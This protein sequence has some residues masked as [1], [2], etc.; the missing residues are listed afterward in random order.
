M[1]LTTAQST[2]LTRLRSIGTS[3]QAVPLSDSAIRTL[4]LIAL[5]DLDLPVAAAGV[6]D[7][8]IPDLFSSS[9][10]SDFVLDGEAI[11]PL[12]ERAL[13]LN[14]EVETY[15]SCLASIHK[16]RLK[17]RQVLASQQFSSM[18]QVA[19]R[20]LLQYGQ[21]T[22]TALA[23]LLVWRKWLYD[24]DNRAAQDTGYLFEPVIAGA[25]GG[26]PVSASRSP[27]RRLGRGG[28]RQVDCIKGFI[29]YE[30]KI[31][32]TIAASGQ[33][34]WAEELSFPEEAR[35][36]GFEPVL[37]V[38]DPTANPKL[39]EL[40]AAFLEAG[41]RVYLGDDAWAHLRA[42]AGPG[43]ARFLEKYIRMPLEEIYFA[44][45]DGE[46]VPD[47]TL[48]DRGTHVDFAVG[49][50]RWSVPRNPHPD[51]EPEIDPEMPV[52]VADS[53]PGVD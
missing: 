44:F 25:I 11:E 16:A 51:L 20:G 27:I 23:G 30:I 31:R 8:G 3:V 1:T 42:E 2:A 15:V 34:R 39:S 13:S 37:V 50:E 41:G 48:S 18:D 5:R 38:L 6:D 7:D 43:M 12:Y 19:P 9:F 53:L 47:L 24:L 29:A 32:I 52:G 26:T 45:D 21:L 46:S 36:S 35:E 10:T 28:G 22:P 4:I 17:Y 49:E 40:T 14:P 33:G